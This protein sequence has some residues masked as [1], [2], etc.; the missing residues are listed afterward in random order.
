MRSGVPVSELDPVCSLGRL[1]VL[2]IRFLI[3]AQSVV[4]PG[5]NNKPQKG[6]VRAG[7]LELGREGGIVVILEANRDTIE[8]V[9]EIRTGYCRAGDHCVSSKK[10]IDNPV[11]G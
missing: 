6:I 11:A 7:R 4:E 5:A 10:C 2:R 1:P 9:C 3:E 8:I